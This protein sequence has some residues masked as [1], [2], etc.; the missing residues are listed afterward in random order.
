MNEDVTPLI[1]RV[2]EALERL[3]PAPPRRTGV[4]RRAPL[5]LRG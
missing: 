5:S 2:A 1:R 4:C 3:A